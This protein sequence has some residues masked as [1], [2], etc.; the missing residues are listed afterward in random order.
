MAT[1]RFLGGDPLL[2]QSWRKSREPLIQSLREENE[3]GPWGP[4]HGSFVQVGDEAFAVYHATDLPGDGRRNRKARVQRLVF[5][6]G[7]PWMGGSVGPLVDE[8][9]MFPGPSKPREDDDK[10]EGRGQ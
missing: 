7:G 8:C 9:E 2:A 6:E 4:G 1:L 10:A 5:A 3:R